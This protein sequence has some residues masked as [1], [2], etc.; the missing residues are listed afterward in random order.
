[1]VRF[2]SLDATS[3]AQVELTLKPQV[4][5]PTNRL[6]KRSICFLNPRLSVFIRVKVLIF[7]I[8]L[9]PGHLQLRLQVVGNLFAVKASVLDENLACPR[10]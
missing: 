3:A 5:Y 10:A 4:L 8:L 1:M 2:F 9:H 6:N 7:R